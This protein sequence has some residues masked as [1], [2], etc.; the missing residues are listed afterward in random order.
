MVL[1]DGPRGF[2]PWLCVRRSALATGKAAPLDPAGSAT[3][4]RSQG[5]ATAEN[6]QFAKPPGPARLASVALL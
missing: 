2:R 3:V 6:G 5:S 1:I 4:A